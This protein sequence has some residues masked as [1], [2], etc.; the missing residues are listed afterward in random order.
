M[1]CVLWTP[2][3]VWILR[4]QLFSESCRMS[5]ELS[6]WNHEYEPSARVAI[7]LIQNSY[8]IFFWLRITTINK[9]FLF[10]NNFNFVSFFIFIL[11]LQCLRKE[12]HIRTHA[13]LVAR[14]L[15]GSGSSV[16][17]PFTRTHASLRQACGM[18]TCWKST[19]WI[20]AFSYQDVTAMADTERRRC[21][22]HK[23]ACEI[24]S[25]RGFSAG[26]SCTSYSKLNKDSKK[27]AT[28]MQRSQ[29]AGEDGHTNVFWS[30]S[31]GH[32]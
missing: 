15:N 16:A 19:C 12:K 4:R 30:H 5:V 31:E 27:N 10:I 17:T 26:F 2:S 14:S 8:Y 21:V 3:L 20:P 22:T 11:N 18:P 24:P 32:D 23:T 9:L 29:D 28:A 1:R 25:L 13:S 6:S 7:W